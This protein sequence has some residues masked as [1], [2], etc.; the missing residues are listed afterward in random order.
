MT[1]DDGLMMDGLMVDGRT[2]GIPPGMPPFPLADIG[3]MGWNVL[4][5]DMTLPLAVLKL[6]A[7]DHNSRWM[8]EF[9]KATGTALAPHGK[10]TMSP[11]L[12]E[13]QLADGAWG[14]TLATVQQVRVARANGIGRI[15]LA[16][17]LVGRQAIDYIAAELA[18]DPSFDFHCLVDSIDGVRQLTQRLEANPPGRPLQVMVEIGAMGGRTG[19]R[20]DDAALGVA[21]A[22]KRSEPL[23]SL[24]GIEGYE[25]MVRSDGDR[26]DAIRA[27]LDRIAGV[28]LACA[29]EDLFAAGPVIL[30]AGG[31]AFY[32]MVAD[33]L[34]SARLGDAGLGRETLVLLR[35]GC[36]LTHDSKSYQTMFQQIRDRMPEVDGF[37]PGPMAALEVWAYVQSRPQRDKAILTVGKRDISYDVDLP[38]P[39]LWF[40][41]GLHDAPV[42]M[43][44]GVAVT[45]LNDQHAHLS[46]PPETDLPETELKVGDMVAFGISHPCTTFDKWQVLFQVND[47]YD[48]V[49]AVKT[50]F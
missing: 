27:F 2:K 7:L 14:M 26:D 24:R 8:A 21:R 13:R 10:T 33:R 38:V 30:S 49:S 22:V 42:S 15:V 12:F 29:R 28:A 34:G 11:A 5:E 45:E 40:R 36:Y 31:S 37:G 44:E 47:R 17:Q 48:I 39:T 23:L 9:L 32:D 20:T 46:L 1:M 19:C 18:R 6:P 50:W 3:G 41:P 16:N 25:G 43:P 35:S 4:R